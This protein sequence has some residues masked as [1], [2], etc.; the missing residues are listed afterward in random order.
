MGDTFDQLRRGIARFERDVHDL[1]SQRFQFALVK[2]ELTLRSGAAL[3]ENIRCEMEQK[4]VRRRFVE[5]RHEIHC[6]E[7]R[8]DFHTL[9]SRRY[10]APDLSSI[11]KLLAYA[12]V[13]L[14]GYR[15]EIAQRPCLFEKTYMP[16][17]QQVKRAA[18]AHHSPPVAFPF[19]PA[20]NQLTLRDDLPQS[21]ALGPFRQ[22]E[23]ELQFYHARSKHRG[24]RGERQ[25]KSAA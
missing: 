22:E 25:M 18:R 14:H 20:E 17:M 6:G 1:A 24:A 16:G 23:S 9:G 5:W 15:Q 19:A 7:S 4:L 12:R 13:A 11:S 21:T 10:R 2:P 3:D 8:D